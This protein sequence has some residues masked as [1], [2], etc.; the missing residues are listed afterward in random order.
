MPRSKS[1]VDVNRSSAGPVLLIWARDE[2][3]MP[4]THAQRLADQVPNTHLVWI[5]DTRTL[6]PIDQPRVLTDHRQAFLAAHT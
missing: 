2:R 3:R 1:K 4:P 5:D 6:M